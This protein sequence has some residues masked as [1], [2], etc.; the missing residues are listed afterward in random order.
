[1]VFASAGGY[2]ADGISATQ[3][4][5]LYI[6]V[7]F[8]LLIEFWDVQEGISPDNLAGKAKYPKKRLSSCSTE[9]FA[10]FFYGGGVGVLGYRYTV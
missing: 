2:A 3:M 5:K 6:K 1:M 7:S 9:W 4:L 10:I 8:L